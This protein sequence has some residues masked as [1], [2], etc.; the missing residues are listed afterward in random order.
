MAAAIADRA[1][2]VYMLLDAGANPSLTDMSGATAL[3]YARGDSVFRLL[4][5]A[6]FRDTKSRDMETLAYFRRRAQGSLPRHPWNET[7]LARVI[8]EGFGSPVMTV[9][10]IPP[11]GAKLPYS[12]PAYVAAVRLQLEL[13]AN[14]NE[15]LTWEGV[16]WT[17]LA[18]ALQR[19]DPGVIAT[20]LE[21]G[22]DPNHRWCVSVEAEPTRRSRAA[23]CTPTNGTTPLMY[24]ARLP[25]PQLDTLLLQHGADP[26][27]RDWQGRT[28][29]D[30]RTARATP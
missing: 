29:A 24:V 13:G 20:L 2:S 7:P 16:D 4:Q 30:Y 12:Y 19:P 22:A 9:P 5:A 21:H 10:P 23:E 28:A 1:D 14:P 15:R 8:M 25:F 27:L 18:L 11:R 26:A 6:L 17:P 3:D